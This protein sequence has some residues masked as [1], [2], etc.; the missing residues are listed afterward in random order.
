LAKTVGKFWKFYIIGLVVV[1]YIAITL[2]PLRYSFIEIGDYSLLFQK[3]ET[4]ANAILPDLYL[5]QN[6]S[7]NEKILLTQS[8]QY[9]AEIIK[10][11]K[12]AQCIDT[13]SK[14]VTT[15]LRKTKP[16]SIAFIQPILGSRGKLFI[17][18]MWLNDDVKGRTSSSLLIKNDLD[19]FKIE[20]NPKYNFTSSQDDIAYRAGTMFHEM[21]HNLGYDHDNVTQKTKYEDVQGS[22]V[23]E[24]GWC[25][26]PDRMGINYL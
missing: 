3:I 11:K 14:R 8:Y 7:S 12:F 25:A 19:N 9:F 23:Y 18:K 24:A 1:S 13:N 26:L 21:V 6:F 20:V 2:N 17:S 10:K 16:F 15:T 4:S 5:D 22:A